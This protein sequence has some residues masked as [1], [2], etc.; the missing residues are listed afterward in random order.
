ML[1]RNCN[2]RSWCPLGSLL[3]GLVPYCLQFIGVLITQYIYQARGIPK[4]DE[5]LRS[6]KESF[7]ACHL[8][9]QIPLRSQRSANL[10]A[11]CVNDCKMV[12]ALRESVTYGEQW[13]VTILASKKLPPIPNPYGLVLSSTAGGDSQSSHCKPKNSQIIVIA[14]LLA[15]S[16]RF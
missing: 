4:V 15:T 1:C 14:L 2:I 12:N 7:V 11:I 3:A 6:L 16:G 13:R 9:T 5:V 8:K 10:I